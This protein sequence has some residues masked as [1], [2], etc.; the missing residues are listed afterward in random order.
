M[1]QILFFTVEPLIIHLSWIDI[2]SVGC[3][4]RFSCT[5]IKLLAKITISLIHPFY[6]IHSPPTRW[7]NWPI[8]KVHI[9]K[10]W[11]FSCQYIHVSFF[12]IILNFRK[13]LLVTYV[14]P[15]LI[16]NSKVKR[17]SFLIKSGGIVRPKWLQNKLNLH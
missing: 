4:T 7:N 1:S 3:W 12:G 5:M 9:S 8:N 10:L 2:L 14:L 17:Q 16:R 6:P 11:I 13:T 15:G